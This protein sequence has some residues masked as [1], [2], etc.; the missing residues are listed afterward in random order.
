[1]ELFFELIR[2]NYVLRGE[3]EL[4]DKKD[5]FGMMER[6]FLWKIWIYHGVKIKV[7]ETREYNNISFLMYNDKFYFF[8]SS[9]FKKLDFEKIYLTDSKSR[10]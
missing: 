5:W 9:Y 4:K 7:I 1:M 3:N 2:F 10:Y 8:E 6:F